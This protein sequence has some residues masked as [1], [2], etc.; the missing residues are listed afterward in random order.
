MNEQEILN[1]VRDEVERVKRGNK[2]AL[3]LY[4]KLNDLKKSIDELRKELYEYVISE[5]DKYDKREDII[6]GDYKISIVSRTRYSYKEDSEYSFIK[7]KLKNRKNLIKKATDKGEPLQDSETGEIV[8][9]VEVSW[10]T[11]PKCEYIGN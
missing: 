4:P 10:S 1:Q 3:D 9:P 5:A 11:H 2:S 8:E 6:K 7:E